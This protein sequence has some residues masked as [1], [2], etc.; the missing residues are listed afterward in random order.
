MP[1]LRLN[2]VAAG[3]GQGAAVIVDAADPSPVNLL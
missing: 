3:A 2:G 1:I